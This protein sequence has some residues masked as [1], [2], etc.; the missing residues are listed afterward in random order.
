MLDLTNT[1]GRGAGT[2]TAGLFLQEFINDI[3]WV[4]LDI[5]GTSFLPKPNGYLPK[6]ATG[7]L[8][9]T[10]YHLVNGQNQVI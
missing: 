6:G 2:I 4:H 9:K 7:V 10:L 8:V 5:A 3:P 1:G